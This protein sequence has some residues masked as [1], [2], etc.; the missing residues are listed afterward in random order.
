MDPLRTPNP[1]DSFDPESQAINYQLDF[2]KLEHQS[3]NELI[4]RIDEI[5]QTIKNW[6]VLIWAGSLSLALGQAKF[7]PFIF[8]TAILPIPFWFVDG[9][10]R[11][12]QRSCIFR[13][14]KI[15]AFLN[16]PNL[17]E[18]VLQ[19]KLVDFKVLDV[20]GVQYKN[21]DDFKAF[22]SV[23]HTLFYKEVGGFYGALILLS[24]LLGI[25]FMLLP[26]LRTQ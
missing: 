24:L 5:T 22:I 26:G 15:S 17:A 20:R 19:R 7:R 18:S 25:C 6:T 8:L 16:G 1:T 10:W 4:K 23:R 13:S 11:R 21:D 9:W 12:I 3:I 2:L 14:H